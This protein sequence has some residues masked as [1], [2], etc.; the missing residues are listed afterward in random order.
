MVGSMEY[1]SK[2]DLV[3]CIFLKYKEVGVNCRPK[4]SRV[5]NRVPTYAFLKIFAHFFK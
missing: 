1:F 5:R 4:Y 3:A 2:C